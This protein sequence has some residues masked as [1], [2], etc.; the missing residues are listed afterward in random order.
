[1]IFPRRIRWLDGRYANVDGIPFVTPIRTRTSPALFAGFSID[2]VAARELL[3]G[4]ELHPCRVW[5]R[6]VLVIAVVN[7]LDTAIGRYVEFCVGVLCTRGPRAAPR[8]V[9][10]TMLP[11]FGTGVFIYDLPVS[12]EVSVKGGRGIWGMAKRQANLDFVIGD[13]TVSS[14]Y[15][16]DG[17]LV[18]RIDVPRG[19]ARLPFFVKGVGYGDF[20]GMLTKSHIYLKGRSGFST[21]PER[22]RLVLG[23]HPR[24]EALKRLHID[25]RPMF[26]GFVPRLEGVLDDYVETWFLTA[27][28]PRPEPEE[29]M[30]DVVG[31]GLSQDWLAPPDRAGSDRLLEE[32]S[33]GQ[34]VGRAPRPP[35]SAVTTDSSHAGA[36]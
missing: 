27:R 30:G 14:Q 5:S 8:L 32:L 31:L 29:G 33:P 16:L 12:S 35:P 9:P 17:Q 4:E 21:R 34:A 28:H 20:R 23:D 25:P 26:S 19:P 18:V 3:P 11:R 24:A 22:A 2:P 15:D 36:S 10:L 13:D 1:M 7:Y 6:G